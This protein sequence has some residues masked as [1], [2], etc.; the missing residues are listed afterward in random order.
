MTEILLVEDEACARTFVRTVLEQR[1]YKV[2]EAADAY[3]ALDILG[4][5]GCHPSL[6]ITDI[7]MPG[8]SGVA[9]AETIGQ[10]RPDLPILFISGGFPAE[11]PL[12]GATRAF[13]AKPFSRRDLLRSVEQLLANAVPNG[14]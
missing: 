2:H 7:E 14:Q 8:M 6:V 4:T 11:L 12:S 3:R 1:G 13:L 9:L 5:E 10:S